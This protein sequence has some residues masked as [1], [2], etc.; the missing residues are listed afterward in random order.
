MWVFVAIFKSKKVCI[1]YFCLLLNIGSISN[2][3]K[4]KEKNTC[5]YFIKLFLIVTK[6]FYVIYILTKEQKMFQQYY[7]LTCYYI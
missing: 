3:N 2:E 5:N 7:N 1:I 4:E 6:F